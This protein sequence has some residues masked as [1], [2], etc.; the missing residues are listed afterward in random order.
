VPHR[1][2][3]YRYGMEA[4][5]GKTYDPYRTSPT[6]YYY[7]AQGTAPRYIRLPNTRHYVASNLYN[8]IKLAP[9]RKQRAGF[10]RFIYNRF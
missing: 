8:D 9:V 2:P 1:V 6:D 5:N 3:P 4:Y 7:A 10:A